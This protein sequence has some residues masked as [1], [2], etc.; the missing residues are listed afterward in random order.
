[1]PAVGASVTVN[2]A[3]TSWMTVGEVLWIG[4]AN[5]SGNAGAMRITAKTSTSVTLVNLG[6][7]NPAVGDMLK[8][9]YDQDNSGIVDAAESVPDIA[10]ARV[11]SQRTRGYSSIGNSTFE[12]NQRAVASVTTGTSLNQ[13]VQ[14][15][16]L[17]SKNGG[18]KQYGIGQGSAPTGGWHIPGTSFRVSNNTNYITLNTA[19]ASL[20]AGDVDYLYQTVEGPNLR[21]LIDDVHSISILC[22]TNVTGGLKFAVSLR[23]ASAG[24]TYS[25]VKLCTIPVPNVQ[26]LI[27][28]PNIPVFPTA[29]AFSLTS[30]TVGY[31]FSICVSCG[32]TFMTPANDVWV[33]SNVVGAIGMDQLCTKPTGSYLYLGFAQHEPGP[34]CTSP[35][36]KPFSGANGNLEECQRFYTKSYAYGT[37]A[38]TAA[39]ANQVMGT[40]VANQHCYLYA[41][42][43]K[44]MAKIPT[45]IGYSPATGAVNTVRDVTANADRAT[46]GTASPADSGFSGFTI[47][48]QNAATAMYQY[49][50]TADTGW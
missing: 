50:Y 29:G 47:S 41:A 31:V 40:V 48:T 11:I 6:S 39:G 28:L 9:Q 34:I 22:M 4:N 10:I 46:T 12:V 30:G 15:R 14:D 45:V 33:N 1:V 19:Q 27:T 18:T 38:G 37:V 7:S 2:V 20:A 42:F 16:W 24:A 25:L 32:T 5:G 43:K 8:S 49:H 23:D 3:D 17:F 35:I 21:E 44:V 13:W 26:T 36:D